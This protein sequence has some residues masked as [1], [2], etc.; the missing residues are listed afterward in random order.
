MSRLGRTA[1]LFGSTA[2]AAVTGAAMA[3]GRF[4][5]YF[6]ISFGAALV[7]LGVIASITLLASLRMLLQDG[8]LP[9]SKDRL[10]WDR[11]EPP[12]TQ[13]R[14]FELNQETRQRRMRRQ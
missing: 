11:K 13:G 6:A 1:T 14:L 8:R 12:S 5:I 9:T 10:G 4:A 7:A 3:S 2:T